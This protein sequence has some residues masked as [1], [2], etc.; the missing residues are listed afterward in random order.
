M[1]PDLIQYFIN[2]KDFLNFFNVVRKNG[3]YYKGKFAIIGENNLTIKEPFARFNNK[4]KYDAII[5][6]FPSYFLS[7][8]K[9]N[10]LRNNLTSKGTLTII[11]FMKKSNA[12]TIE[13][14]TIFN[15][16]LL[17]IEHY[18]VIEELRE[19]FRKLRYSVKK[20]C[21]DKYIWFFKISNDHLLQD[22]HEMDYNFTKYPFSSVDRNYIWKTM[23][24]LFGKELDKN[25]ILYDG[26]QLGTTPTLDF[27]LPQNFH[28]KN[29]FIAPFLYNAID[30]RGN[31]R[32]ILKKWFN[33]NNRLFIPILKRNFLN[34]YFNCRWIKSIY[35]GILTFE[36]IQKID[37]VFFLMEKITQNEHIWEYDNLKFHNPNNLRIKLHKL[38]NTNKMFNLYTLKP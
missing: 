7:L 9:I 29:I 24:E 26:N 28:N 2:N 10:L 18:F 12:G 1:H 36:A 33:K 3:R 32:I 35:N 5:L 20:K 6:F 8:D 25:N 27:Y 38:S 13:K 17:T 31:L 21:I 30:T 11:D 4:I 14:T 23:V 15:G 37:S 34:H 19:N 22:P 16:E